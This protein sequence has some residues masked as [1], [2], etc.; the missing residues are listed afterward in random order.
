VADDID[1]IERDDVVGPHRTDEKKHSGDK[2]VNTS[3]RDS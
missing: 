2:C 3:W 1:R